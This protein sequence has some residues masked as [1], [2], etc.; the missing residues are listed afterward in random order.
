MEAAT[1]YQRILGVDYGS[2]RVGLSL[3][4]P[5]GI[6]A[7]PI[8]ALKNDL[9]LFLNLQQ[10]SI[11]ENVRLIVVGMPFNLKGQQAQ[12]A[13]EVQ[14]FIELLKIKL[15]I[16]V[17]AWDERFTTSM[18]HQTMRTMGT[19]KKERQK[20]DGRIDSMAA[21]IILQGFLDNTKHSH[22]C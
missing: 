4:D 6:I 22:S 14:K 12:K 19:K 20:K 15:S 2:Q 7:Q 16:E 11:R 3:S 5:L 8:D 21:A 18:A 17:V 13:D 10:L 9:S 1:T